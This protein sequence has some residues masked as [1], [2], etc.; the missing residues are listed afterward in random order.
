MPIG[1]QQDET[2]YVIRLEGDLDVAGAKELRRVLIEGIASSKRVEVDLAR[3]TGLDIT[4]LQLLW[5]AK[6]EA[7]KAGISAIF[8]GTPEQIVRVVREAGFENFLAMPESARADDDGLA[9]A[10]ADDRQ[11]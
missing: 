8:G 10:S 1:V 2:R 7:Q 5:A 3:A 4:A 9:V 6:G 11:V